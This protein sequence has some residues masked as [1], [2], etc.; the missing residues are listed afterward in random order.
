MSRRPALRLIRGGKAGPAPRPTCVHCGRAIELGEGIDV[1]SGPGHFDCRAR[2]R[3]E[4][5]RAIESDL[6]FFKMLGP[7]TSAIPSVRER[8]LEAL[9]E[10]GEPSSAVLLDVMEQAVERAVDVDE[11]RRVLAR[12]LIR[13]WRARLD[14]PSHKAL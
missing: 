9:S 12:S 2:A 7:I 11:R 5:L 8:L 4:A 14:L 10:P 6:A 13:S 1:G 3:S